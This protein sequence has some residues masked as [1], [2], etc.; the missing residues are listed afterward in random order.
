MFTEGLKIKIAILI[1]EP[2]RTPEVKTNKIV[3]NKCFDNDFDVPTI[4]GNT[5]RGSLILKS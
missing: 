3:L 5:K 2:E 4:R 1:N